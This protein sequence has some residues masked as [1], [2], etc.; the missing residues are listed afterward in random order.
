MSTIVGT[1]SI[2]T[3]HSWT[4]APQVRHAQSVSSLITSPTIAT[5]ETA[6]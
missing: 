1:C 2:I 5:G 4:Q 6:R 3:G